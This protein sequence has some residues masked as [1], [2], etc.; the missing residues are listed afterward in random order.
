MNFLFE[1]FLI[2]AY[3][4]T[5]F[6][7]F[8]LFFSLNHIYYLFKMLYN[9][10]ISG[11]D[12]C[13][14]LNENQNQVLAFLLVFW[15]KQHVND[16][17]DVAVVMILNNVFCVGCNTSVRF[18]LFFFELYEKRSTEG[19]HIYCNGFLFQPSHKVILS[20]LYYILS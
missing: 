16:L 6:V 17:P 19:V 7:V 13:V 3:Y 14:S 4:N 9:F 5:I 10:C 18:F 1:M 2:I 12:V 20:T 11:L 8:F 15:L